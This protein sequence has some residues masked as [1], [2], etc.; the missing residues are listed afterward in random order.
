MKKNDEFARCGNKI[1]MTYLRV[2]YY[3]FCGCTG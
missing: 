1:I 2:I 3:D